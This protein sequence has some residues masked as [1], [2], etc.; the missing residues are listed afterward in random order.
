MRGGM[1][2]DYVREAW[3]YPPR[4]RHLGTGCRWCCGTAAVILAVAAACLRP[5]D[6]VLPGC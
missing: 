2:T 6:A 3:K 1:P 5:G 4:S